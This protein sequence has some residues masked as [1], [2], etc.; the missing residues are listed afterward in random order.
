MITQRYECKYLISPAQ[1]ARIRREI[2]PFVRPDPFAVSHGGRYR[3]T[4]A[5]L[6][7][8]SLRLHRETVEGQRDRIK[9]RVRG[10]GQ[11][12]DSPLFLEIKRR[13]DTLVTKQRA[14][15]PRSAALSLLAGLP[16]AG[17]RPRSTDPELETFL[18]RARV[19]AARPVLEVSY[20][21][22]AWVGALDSTQRLTFDRRITVWPTR[23]PWPSMAAPGSRV[24]EP[25]L[26]VLELKFCDRFP[27]WMRG[28][29]QRHD[30]V[31]LSFSK[32]SR[33]VEALGSRRLAAASATPWSGSA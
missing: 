29:V 15:L 25:R 24:L 8:P 27:A 21:R 13:I 5:Y 23:R 12:P 9:L 1:A 6:D 31:R 2:R 30:L 3:I 11:D 17:G 28:I 26:V 20:E 4:S 19:L 7:T 33:G 10:Y 32:Y 22:E 14:M 16:G 18:E